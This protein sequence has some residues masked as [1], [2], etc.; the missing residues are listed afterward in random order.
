MVPVGVGVIPGV[1][2]G[3]LFGVD[4]GVLAGVL[5]GV[6]P[7]RVEVGVGV[8]TVVGSSSSIVKLHESDCQV[9]G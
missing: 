2:A 4:A 1:D 6:T 9:T 5:L 8:G 3:V 7:G